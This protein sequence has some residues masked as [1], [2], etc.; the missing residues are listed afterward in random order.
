MPGLL[1]PLR[2]FASIS[3]ARARVVLHLLGLAVLLSGYSGAALAWRDQ[4]RIDQQNA[5]LAANGA[6]SLSPLDSRAGSQQLEEQYGK[7]GV[8]S[9]GM[10]EWARSL[11]HGRRLAETLVVLSSAAAIGC[12][13]AARRQSR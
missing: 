10:A 4:E 2:L 6:D 5:W 12:F 7:M 8:M 3:Q 13:I 11:A 9:A 1:V